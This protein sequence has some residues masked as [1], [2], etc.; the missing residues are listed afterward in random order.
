M[1]RLL[2]TLFSLSAVLSVFSQQADEAVTNL[3]HQILDYPQEKVFVQLDRPQYTA[4]DTIWFR[5]HTVSEAFHLPSAMSRGIFVHLYGP[6]KKMIER[7]TLLPM[8]KR[9]YSSFLVLPEQMP[10]GEY[11]LQAY[12]EQM[13]GK[14]SNAYFTKSFLVQNPVRKYEADASLPKKDYEVQF[15]PEGGKLVAGHP[16][17]VAFTIKDAKGMPVEIKGAVYETNGPFVSVMRTLQPGIGCFSLPVE[18]GKS[19]FAQLE[20]GAEKP[21]YVE[22]PVATESGYSL[23]VTDMV[24]T[25]YVTALQSGAEKLSRP[26]KVLLL[27]R[28]VPELTFQLTPLRDFIYIGKNELESGV[29]EIV[30][31]DENN[32]VQSQRLI[33]IHNED[34]AK[35]TMDLRPGADSINKKQL[36]FDL[37]VSDANGAPMDAEFSVAIYPDTFGAAVSDKRNIGSEFLL[38]SDLTQHAVLNASH[39]EGVTALSAAALDAWLV[40]SRWPKFDIQRAIDGDFE[41][42]W[43]IGER[44]EATFIR[45]TTGIY[46]PL[47]TAEKIK[48]EKIRQVDLKAVNIYPEQLNKHIKPYN[49]VNHTVTGEELLT[50]GS[51]IQDYLINL[52]GV[53][54]NYDTGVLLIRDGSVSYMIDGYNA[55]VDA[56][57]M[58]TASEI[59]SVDVLKDPGNMGLFKFSSS[60]SSNTAVGGVIAIWTKRAIDASPQKN[61][62]NFKPAGHK[63]SDD[64][65]RKIMPGT[66]DIWLSQ[67]PNT[68]RS[69]S[70]KPSIVTDDK[71]KAVIR[72]T[73]AAHCQRYVVEMN[74]VTSNGKLVFLRKS[75]EIPAP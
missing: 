17:K 24:D 28:G 9:L 40:A 19:Y 21:L 25:Y 27:L 46:S 68:A 3:R 34:Q 29:H 30:L 57:N 64:V 74:G 50:G 6:D 2:A 42:S 10:A 58:L 54:Y 63:I 11:T 52:P 72:F 66:T 48:K 16:C 33:F 55:D 35:I 70:W 13:Q 15:Y 5:A 7:F 69:N 22:L 67:F 56:V 14:R 45:D 43:D 71:G 41:S 38:A 12:S 18:A 4:G 73:P 65:R 61:K 44:P 59:E 62:K 20:T 1:K 47:T 60:D 36:L 75:I 23:Q 49:Y 26:L 37:S 31:L 39:F 8:D 51:T 32:R 53:T